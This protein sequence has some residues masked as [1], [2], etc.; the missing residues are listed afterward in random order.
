MDISVFRS[1][2][3]EL[4]VGYAPRTSS[5]ITL[6]RS[7]C[8]WSFLN[9]VT[10]LTLHVPW[11]VPLFAIR[12]RESQ[13]FS[14]DF[15]QHVSAAGLS[16]RLRTARR[17]NWTWEANVPKHTSKCPRCLFSSLFLSFCLCLSPNYRTMLLT[18]IQTTQ[19]VSKRLCY[20][21][22]RQL[23]FNVTN[24]ISQN[25]ICTKYKLM[26]QNGGEGFLR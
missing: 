26:K 23:W 9:L 12:S 19:V 17:D 13:G 3:G 20:A 4:K 18:L 24:L 2:F 22:V 21:G 10:V 15:R 16:W 8:W 5:P 11:H 7:H 6:P 25:C 1:F 14:L